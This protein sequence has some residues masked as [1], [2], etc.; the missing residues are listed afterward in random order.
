MLD[1]QTLIILPEQQALN[2]GC[3]DL[4]HPSICDRRANLSAHSAAKP[5]T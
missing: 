1:Y 2:L 4:R 3:A 5:C